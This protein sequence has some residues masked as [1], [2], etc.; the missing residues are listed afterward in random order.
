MN[1]KGG[2]L[3]ENYRVAPLLSALVGRL[4]AFLLEIEK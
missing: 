1:V 3:N 4:L 2:R